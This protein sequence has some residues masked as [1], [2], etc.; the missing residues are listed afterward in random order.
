MNAGLL[1]NRRLGLWS[2]IIEVFLGTAY[3]DD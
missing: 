1:A 3:A 2:A